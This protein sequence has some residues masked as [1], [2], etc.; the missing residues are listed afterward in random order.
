M[1]IRQRAIQAEDKQERHHAIL[2]AAERLLLR[3]PERIANVA[4]VADEAGLAKGTVYLYFP[5]KE[6]L[7][8]AVHERNI[9]GFFRALIDRLAER[10]A[11]RDRRRARAHAPAHGRAA[12]VPAA[13]RA[14][15]R[16]DGPERADRGRAGVQAADGRAPAERAG[17]G[18]E[19]HFPELRPGDGVAL[20][21]HSY[22]L[23][24]GLW[25][26]SAHAGAAR[27]ARWRPTR[28]VAVFAYDYP[29]RARPRAARAVVRERS[30]AR[31]RRRPRPRRHRD[32]PARSCPRVRRRCAGGGARRLRRARS[33]LRT[34]VRP[35][36]LA[37]VVAGRRARDRRVRRRSEAAP[38]S[39][40]GFPHR[41]QA[42]RALRR[43]RRA[44]EEGAG[45]RAPRPRRRGPAGRGGE[46]AG[47]GDGDRVQVRAGGIRALPE[48]VPREVHQRV[49]ARRE[50]QHAR[51][52]PGEIRAGEGEPRR[53]AEPGELRDAR[54]ERGRRR[55]GD[56][57]RAGPGRGGRAVRRAHRARG[58]ARSRDQRAGEQDRRAR[59]READRRRAVGD[60]GQ[61]VS[62]RRSARCRRP[63]IRRRARSPCACRSSIPIPRSSGA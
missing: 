48:P 30:A 36:Q 12:A 60:A 42:R 7:L 50:A 10:P 17:A 13:R 58:G 20:L 28:R 43:R 51:R 35:V 41:R 1:V 6:E 33:A 4:E 21:R 3:S 11:D 45:A 32:E 37:Q 46:G 63:S 5:S 38:R 44:R 16:A 24:I 40:P 9:D 59:A 62:R 52:E 27:A 18:L 39:G 47:R 49:R 15:L 22:A 2:D 61:D 25:Q 14:L 54:R 31:C 53:V 26:M 8:L 29:G 55:H 19:R 34:S 56:R 23:I 57:R